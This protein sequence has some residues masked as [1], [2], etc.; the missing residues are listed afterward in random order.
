MSDAPSSPKMD[1]ND[2][3]GMISPGTLRDADAD[4]NIKAS[5]VPRS[6]GAMGRKNF[7]DRTFSKLDKGSVRGS[8]MSLVSAAVGGGVLSLPFVFA[9]SGWVTGV[10]LLILG[11]FAGIWSNYLIAE[12]AIR[13]KLVNF[14]QVAKAGGGAC[15]QKLLAIM[16]LIYLPGSCI[17]Y[18][19]LFNAL[20]GYVANAFGLDAAFVN[21]MEFRAIVG[22]PAAL[23]FYFPLSMK[24]DMS[25]FAYGGV[26]SVIALLYVALIMVI[27]MPWYNSEAWKDEKRDIQSFPVYIDLN[28]FTSC[29]I[30]FF[31]Y[32]CQVQLMPVYSELVNPNFRRIKKVIT[33]SLLTDMFF[34]M[35]IGVAGYMSTFNYTQSIVVE[36]PPLEGYSKDYYMLVGALAICLI[37]V[38][39]L[40]VNYHPW[41]YQ[42]FIFCFNRDDF[43]QCENAIITSIF[44]IFCT[45]VA[46]VFPN[47]TSVLSILGGLCSCTMSYLIPTIAYVR[48][49]KFKWY[50]HTNLLPILFFGTLT[51]IGYISVV[52][53][54]FLLV[55]GNKTGTIGNRTDLHTDP[56]A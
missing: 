46:I 11:A 26:A 17:T 9:L 35:I 15:L 56:S 27:E 53:T 10:F 7:M 32:T 13:K 24:R 33:R 25:A 50:H 14:D 51:I 12:V 8:I 40:P 2:G 45:G 43:N 55:S 38:A 47:I 52:A 21:T 20:I 16:I 31:A 42:I 29:S 34:Y 30:T 37:M 28:I 22:V 3:T 54:V 39:S 5:K 49:S 4:V 6:P 18:M 44:M 48:M 41:R 19:I 23:L 1:F 36:R